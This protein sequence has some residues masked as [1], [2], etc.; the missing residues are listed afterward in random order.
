MELQSKIA[1]RI[2]VM[3]IKR[4]I[5]PLLLE[6]VKTFKVLL[7]TGP[8]QVGKSTTL[9]HLFGSG[10]YEYVTLDDLL[11]LEIAKRDP[12][13]FFLNHPGKLIIDEI[14]YAPELFREIKHRVD[15]NHEY[16]QYILTGSQT[17]DLMSG[18]TESLAG[19]VGIVHLSG[20][21]IR[22][23][24]QDQYRK[25]FIPT[26]DFLHAERLTVHGMEL[27]N[28]IHRGS[29]PELTKLQEMDH[30]LY[31]ASYVS[32]YIERDVR[33]ITNIKDLNLFAQFVRVLAARVSQLVNY[34]DMAKELGV[35]SKT[36]KA[37]VSMLEASGIVILV[38]P[39]FNNRL[40]R[41]VKTPVLYFMDVGLLTYLLKW[42]TP[43]T[44]MS[45]AMSGPIFESFAVS[46]I[47]KSFYN[48]G[49][50]NPAITFYRDRDQKEIDL[51][52][53]SSGVLYP[54]EIKQ[55]SS[56]NMNMAKHFHLL[57][58]AEGF[59]MGTQLILC[60]VEKLTYLT[61]DLIAY[62]VGAI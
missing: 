49:M 60:Q 51:I 30:N 17:F 59:K 29:L 57:E 47:V 9:Q 56:P 58:K 34:A 54:I 31:Y 18:I 13:A 38:Q 46:E 6:V 4:A 61:S 36:V 40:S 55:T 43:E 22:E 7:V 50:I 10:V 62:P 44:L 24:L 21:S 16:G 52:V 45:G 5:E 27:W 8:R 11:E 33:A 15:R 53:E 23:V 37:W 41:V 3:Y 48:A 32:T 28:N 14:Q 39:F 19:R 42:T 26:H 2:I 25:P 1:E 12:K 35:D 20:L